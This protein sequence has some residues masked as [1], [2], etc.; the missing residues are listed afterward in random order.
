MAGGRS[1][2]PGKPIAARLI[3]THV[4]LQSE[5]GRSGQIPNDRSALHDRHA[6]SPTASANFS[7]DEWLLVDDVGY[8]PCGL[9]AGVAVFH[10]GLVGILTGNGE[11]VPLSS[12]LLDA[13]EIAM[14][15]LQ[16]QAKRAGAEGVV[17]VRLSIEMPEG[18]GHLARFIAIGSGIRRK[19]PGRSADERPGDPF[20]SSLSGQEFAILIKGGYVP[21]GLVLG[22]C[23]YHVA[24]MQPATWLRTTFRS[25]EMPTYTSALYEARELAMT[26]LQN[27]ARSLEADGVVG[28]ETTERS[29]V[30]GSHVI[31]FFVIGTAV[32]VIA[33]EHQPLR[34]EFVL[35]VHDESIQTD[36]GAILGSTRAEERRQ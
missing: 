32:K 29:H 21:V 7:V 18:K 13:R 35:S 9:L 19:R 30:W 22:V 11:V 24:R 25:S 5:E 36:P 33:D 28:V 1:G 4:E 20:L 14:R 17:G 8:E 23:V 34:P 10:I 3:E 12:A 31:E 15:K 26:R 6:S 27:E 16:T 2:N